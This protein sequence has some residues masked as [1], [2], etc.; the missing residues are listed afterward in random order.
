MTLGGVVNV[1][2][3]PNVSR[4]VHPP[5]VSSIRKVWKGESNLAALLSTNR[6]HR[7]WTANG[8]GRGVVVYCSNCWGYTSA[9]PRTLLHN[10]TPLSLADVHIARDRLRQRVHPRYSA[11][12]S[13]PTRL[14][15]NWS[16]VS[17]ACW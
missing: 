8:Q 14:H 9:Y 11:R 6:G 4:T 17:I 15:V 5:S 1:R 2:Y 16:C 12:L 3:A 13:L 10:C 7:L